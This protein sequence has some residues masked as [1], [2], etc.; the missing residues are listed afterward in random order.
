MLW[1]EPVEGNHGE[2]V[3]GYDLAS[4]GLSGA[5]YVEAGAS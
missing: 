4:A 1:L 2:V 3:L 5:I